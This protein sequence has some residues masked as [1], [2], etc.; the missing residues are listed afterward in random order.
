MTNL[1]HS[2]AYTQ[3]I[4]CPQAEIRAHSCSFHQLGPKIQI[5]EESLGAV[6]ILTTTPTLRSQDYRKAALRQRGVG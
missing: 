3:R 6:L 4:L 1:Y 2:L 5:Y